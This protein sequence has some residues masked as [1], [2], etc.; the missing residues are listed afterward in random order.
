MT[1]SFYAEF[2]INEAKQPADAHAII[3]SVS[4]L[5]RKQVCFRRKIFALFL[6]QIVQ[7]VRKFLLHLAIHKV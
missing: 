3:R 4:F 6:L 2:V 5:R 7:I 1:G